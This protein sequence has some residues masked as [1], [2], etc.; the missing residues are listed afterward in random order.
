MR[1]HNRF[2]LFLL[3]TVALY[4][5]ALALLGRAGEAINRELL[6]QRLEESAGS[7][8][9]I[10]ALER[11][12]IARAVFDYTYWDDMVAFIRRPDREWA[13][14]NI[15]HA[16]A[17]FGI[18]YGWVYDRAL[19]RIYT[20]PSGRAAAAELTTDQLR[21]A[22]DHNSF[23]NFYGRSPH[24]ELIEYFT[25]PVQPTADHARISPPQG[26]FVAARVLEHRYLDRLAKAV[27]GT[28]SL[29]VP[30]SGYAGA[31]ADLS[32]ARVELFRNLLDA[33][34]HPVATLQTQR[35][36]PSVPVLRRWQASYNA[37]Y[38]GFA[39]LNLL[40]LG[41]FVI[42]WVR[43]PL[44][45]I[46][47]SLDRQDLTPAARYLH[48]K[49]E[50][51]TIVR[52]IRNFFAQREAL[53]EE[54]EMRKQSEH[55]LRE[56]RDLAD[57]SAHAK[58]DF[59][60]V[61]SHELRTPLN[62]VIGYAGMLLDEDPRPDQRQPL[63]ALK[64]AA[65]H[66]LALINDVL[67]F[68]KIDA[69]R[70]TLEERPFDP[71]ALA[72]TMLL[73][74]EP[75]ARATDVALTV[76]LGPDL[77]PRVVGDQLRIAQVLGNLLS[78]AMKFTPAGCV[79]LAL[80][81]AGGDAATACIRFRVSDTG[82]GIPR[83]KQAAVF[84]PFTQAATDTTRHYGGTGLGLSIV[85]RLLQVMGSDIELESTPG[86]GST[87]SFTLA[88]PRTLEGAPRDDAPAALVSAEGRRV[89][90]VEDNLVSRQ[91]AARMLARWG[92][93]VETAVNGVEAVAKAAREPFDLILMDLQ[94]PE[95]SGIT[96]TAHI[97]H[98]A[99]SANAMTPILAFTATSP[100]E[101]DAAAHAAGFTGTIRKPV[102]P[103]RLRV[104]LERY[105]AGPDSDASRGGES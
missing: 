35:D 13:K 2:L 38:L 60:S 27:G 32:A 28:V 103:A 84:E 45:R 6:D 49:H 41:G 34:G 83:D 46:S 79:T 63:E 21:V 66:L 73:A 8:D 20:V 31:H 12:P 82:I 43:N 16:L 75:Q 4:A 42:I 90:V 3:I 87:F 65:E 97:R 33:G 104:A 81:H 80:E 23:S 70:L 54:I 77:P 37:I 30:A 96:A 11:A 57:R 92:I 48:A 40:L 95:M 53:L 101:D 61:M 67:D 62:I 76:D 58:A 19:R 24:G 85:R 55:H 64:T 18:Q 56:A 78:N 1:I 51:G 86:R 44:Q 69:G 25:A 98:D 74:F 72:N 68:S 10:L 105:L 88:L 14:Q 17:P 26:W 7:L 71:A 47:Q 59:L 89:L 39:A 91:L 36:M 100:G 52:L 99:Q 93:E 15:D 5:G 102:D 29:Q 22:V 50:F 9:A 94:M